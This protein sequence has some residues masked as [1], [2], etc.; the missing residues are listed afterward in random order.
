MLWVDKYSPH[1]YLD[2]LSDE[3]IN[4][5]VAQWLMTWRRY[6]DASSGAGGHAGRSGGPH[7]L[8]HGRSSAPPPEHKL[9]LLSGP[10]GLQILL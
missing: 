10:P 1:S 7:S 2:L 9:L 3:T 5:E 6:M 4:R 8:H